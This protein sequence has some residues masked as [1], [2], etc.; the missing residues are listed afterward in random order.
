[1]SPCG[2]AQIGDQCSG[3][4]AHGRLEHESVRIDNGP[5]AVPPHDH[6]RARPP[7]HA[8]GHVQQSP[9]ASVVTPPRVPRAEVISLGVVSGAVSQR[10][11]TWSRDCAV[12]RRAGNRKINKSVGRRNQ[13][14]TC[15]VRGKPCGDALLAEGLGRGLTVV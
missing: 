1:M 13:E 12:A 3:S 8:G 15:A 14:M 11:A 2:S 6:E 7:Q 5:G 10:Y 4:Q 9:P